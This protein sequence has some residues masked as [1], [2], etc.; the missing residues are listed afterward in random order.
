[1]LVTWFV[2]SSQPCATFF[3]EVVNWSA[4]LTQKHLCCDCDE[5]VS[6]S[7]MSV[8]H[9]LCCLCDELVSWPVVLVQQYCAAS[10]LPP[11]PF[12]YYQIAFWVVAILGMISLYFNIQ[13]HKSSTS[14]SSSSHS[15]AE[16]Y[17]DSH[18]NSDHVGTIGRI[19]EMKN[20]G[21]GFP[22]NVV[23]SGTT[24][25]EMGKLSHS[26]KKRWDLFAGDGQLVLTLA[27]LIFCVIFVRF[28]HEDRDAPVIWIPIVCHLNDFGDLVFPR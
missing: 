22:P 8:R 9:Y 21:G 6:W 3:D 25:V 14:T 18:R 5:L 28:Y 27:L 15:G 1:M 4:V 16:P 2:M 20:G 17:G 12:A 19:G 23:V 24:G 13:H 11:T 7:V 10:R 26:T